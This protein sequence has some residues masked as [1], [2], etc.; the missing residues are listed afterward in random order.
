MR[1]LIAIICF[2]LA[3]SPLVFAQDKGKDDAKK[4]APAAEAQA[5]KGK[6][7][8]QKSGKSKGDEKNAEAPKGGRA[9]DDKADGDKKKSQ[10]T[11]KELS[12]AQK[13]RQERRDRCNAQ[14]GEKKGDTRKKFMSACEKDLKK[15][16][17]AK[18]KVQQEK[19][20]ACNKEAG[21]KKLKDDDRKKF[22]NEC[23]SGKK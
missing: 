17:D 10:K 12:P 20:T 16:D 4:A 19:L 5:G 3:A 15:S 22:I 6:D 21:D 2:V 18:K 14:A 1:N 13:A 11:K 7:A 8:D 9:K 23:L